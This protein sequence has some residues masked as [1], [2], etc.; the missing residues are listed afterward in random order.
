MESNIDPNMITSISKKYIMP[1]ITAH[2]SPFLADRNTGLGNAMF[3]IASCYG[4]SKKL[5]TNIIFNNVHI[6]GNILKERFNY[7]HKD[8]IL[9]NVY[10][11]HNYSISF[12][13]TIDEGCGNNKS[14]SIS[15]VNNIINSSN[16]SIIQGYLE[17]YSYFE[18]ISEFIKDLFQPDNES[19]QYINNKYGH[20]LNSESFTPIS[21]HF[22]GHEFLTIQGHPYDYDYY[23]RAINYISS[24]V[25][26]PYFLI[27]TDDINSIDI[28][29]LHIKNY[30]FITNNVDYIDLWTMSMCKHNILFTSTFSWW[31]AFL[32]KNHNKI[33]I[34]NK[35]YNWD[36]M[37]IFE[38]I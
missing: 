32:N 36:I 28:S 38:A 25:N 34:S 5:N 35:H 12:N 2:T 29:K 26:N 23:N 6:Y 31:A 1:Y 27:F 9:R 16:N 10:N 18:D 14:Y 24:K 4:L 37:R 33:V 21:I 19:L 8:T 7:N 15:L 20:I 30:I 11:L 3:Q 22:R 13:Q 17:C